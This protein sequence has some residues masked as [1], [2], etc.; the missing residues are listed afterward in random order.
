MVIRH[1]Q[2][3]FVLSF[4]K[5]ILALIRESCVFHFLL[6]QQYKPIP[7]DLQQKVLELNFG[8]H[9]GA[10][11]A[12]RSLIS[13]SHR[14]RCQR[15]QDRIVFL[16]N[17]IA[18]HNPQVPLVSP[19]PPEGFR[20]HKQWVTDAIVEQK[21]VLR[22]HVEA[23][24]G[25]EVQISYKGTQFKINHVDHGRNLVQLLSGAGS[26]VPVSIDDLVSL[27]GRCKIIN[28]DETWSAQFG[29]VDVS[30]MS[31]VI[32]SQELRC[33]CSSCKTLIGNW[34]VEPPVSLFK[35]SRLLVEE[36]MFSVPEERILLSANRA[37]WLHLERLQIFRKLGLV[38][39]DGF[40]GLQLHY[41]PDQ[42]AVRT[43]RQ[44]NL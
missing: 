39:T 36:K 6:N 27:P 17:T 7:S 29:D 8:G 1:C 19:A 44:K 22:K 9:A 2:F 11:S 13:G 43:Q 14:L 3:N 23:L 24:E 38:R 34:N 5:F 10:R 18:V 4:L 32:I 33:D 20:S 37:N 40:G 26:L 15:G 41:L 28:V 25:T 16:R 35:A 42:K 30:S 12:L 31:K 21:K